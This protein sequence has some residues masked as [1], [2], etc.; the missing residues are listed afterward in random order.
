MLET[1]PTIDQEE[2]V[3]LPR[4]IIALRD[5]TAPPAPNAGVARA[6]RL[7]QMEV[8]DVALTD[9][10]ADLDRYIDHARTAEL[11]GPIVGPYMAK[12]AREER[13]RLVAKQ[14]KLREELAWLRSIS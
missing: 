12:L 4:S 2:E 7:T 8:D 3:S 9:F 11:V 10:V 13:S 5:G 6:A 14:Q 1:T